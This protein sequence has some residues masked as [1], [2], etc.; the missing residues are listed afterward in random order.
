MTGE[1][2]ASNSPIFFL[3]ITTQISNSLPSR[4]RSIHRCDLATNFRPLEFSLD[5]SPSLTLQ[6]FIPFQ[7]LVHKPQMGLD[8]DIEATC[9]DKAA[10]Y[11]GEQSPKWYCVGVERQGAGREGL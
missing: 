11:V 1:Y 2:W 10:A 4:V 7:Q 5:L 6:H 3:K 9:P 8:D